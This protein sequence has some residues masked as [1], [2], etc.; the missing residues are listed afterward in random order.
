MASEIIF[1]NPLAVY[2][3]CG[4]SQVITKTVKKKLTFNTSRTIFPL[5]QKHG[6]NRTSKNSLF[7]HD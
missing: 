5:P 7:F 1:L 3:K 6:S 2:Q 4:A